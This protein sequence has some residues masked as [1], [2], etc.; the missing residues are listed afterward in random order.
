MKV[1]KEMFAAADSVGAQREWA[2]ASS[3]W[4]ATEEQYRKGLEIEPHNQRLRGALKG[5]LEGRIEYA[6]Q[7][8]RLDV[9]LDVAQR[10][11]VS[12][13][14][15]AV[16][17]VVLGEVHE[18]R[19]EF[20]RAERALLRAIGLSAGSPARA[21]LARVRSAMRAATDPLVVP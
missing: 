17:H 15:Y 4:D 1:Q 6:K 18:A 12:F 2:L 20:A 21:G 9:A 8:Q 11:T 5:L 14:R 3:L 19:G 13:P 10:L 16:G 7:D